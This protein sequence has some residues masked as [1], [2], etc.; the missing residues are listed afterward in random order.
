MAD[1]R[2]ELPSTDLAD[3]DWSAI[4]SVLPTKTRGIKRVD[5][6]RVLNGIV[7]RL[8][9]GGAWAGI[10]KRYG[11]HT[12]CQSRFRRWRDA[13]VWDRIV[14]AVLAARGAKAITISAAALGVPPAYRSALT[15]AD[16]PVIWF[17][18]DD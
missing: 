3:L 13:G 7:W 4:Q 16:D 9:T 11:P 5:D 15:P 1:G 2:A 10:P 17:L 12:T 18:I 8:R 14:Q 6:R